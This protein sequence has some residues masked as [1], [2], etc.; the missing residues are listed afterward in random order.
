MLVRQSRLCL[1]RDRRSTRRSRIPVRSTSTI[2]NLI[3]EQTIKV[4]LTQTGI[5]EIMNM[6]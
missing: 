3:Q 5:N 2:V 4:R 6:A 1:G